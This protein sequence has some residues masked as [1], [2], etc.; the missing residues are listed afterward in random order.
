MSSLDCSLREEWQRK[1][2]S[3]PEV[4]HA[5]LNLEFHKRKIRQLQEEL[6][7]AEVWEREL[8]ERL[9]R[10]HYGVLLDIME[11]KSPYI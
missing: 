2:S 9:K 5:K 10:M 8:E 1:I 4:K 11:I 6:T 7:S 3:S